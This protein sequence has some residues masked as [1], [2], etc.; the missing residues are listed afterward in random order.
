[1]PLIHGTLIHLYLIDS[2][3]PDKRHFRLIYLS[4]NIVIG[5]D[6]SYYSYYKQTM[7]TQLANKYDSNTT[8][9]DKV[10]FRLKFNF[11]FNNLNDS[12]Q[13]INK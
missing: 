2:S 12:C 11:F 4:E 7:Y 8:V 1:M 3:K 5:G 6:Y 10:L 13:F 9:C